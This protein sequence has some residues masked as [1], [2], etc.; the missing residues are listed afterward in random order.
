MWFEVLDDL[1]LNEGEGPDLLSSF[2]VGD[3]G[4][5]AARTNVKADHSCSDRYE[6]MLTSRTR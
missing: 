4:G 1:D 5:R 3:A 2:F 6:L